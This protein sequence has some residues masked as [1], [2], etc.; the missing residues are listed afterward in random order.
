MLNYLLGVLI[1]LLGIRKIIAMKKFNRDKKQLKIGISNTTG[2]QE[3]QA[4]SYK[5]VETT[6]GS[7][8][9]LADGIGKNRLGL[10]ASQTAI[11]PFETLFKQYGNI[12]NVYYFF[13]RAF[14]VANFEILKVLD[15]RQGG[16]SIVSS[17]IREKT[18]TYAL[19]GD[20][21]IAI[22]RN[23]ELIPL[24]EGHTINVLA[25]QSFRQGKITKQKALW[26]L[27][28]NRLWNYVG[29]DGFKEIEFFDVPV[30][31]QSED[32]IILMTKGIY[33]TL[34]WT[35]IED[36]LKTTKESAHKKAQLI[37]SHI[38]QKSNQSRDNG[39]VIILKI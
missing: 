18:L 10:V 22:F 28:E 14:N 26:A 4:D 24:S 11:R 6:Q 21:K 20:I 16:A 17:V 39:T 23:Q 37:T 27:Q 8:I 15:E 13:K 30:K 19:A 31:L 25:N 9:V 2:D 32:E 36:I 29:Q 12:D 1:I 5:I 38:N 35:E 7:M 33:N 34:K 3:I